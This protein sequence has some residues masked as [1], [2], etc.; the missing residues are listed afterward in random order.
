MIILFRTRG[1]MNLG[2]SYPL[3]SEKYIIKKLLKDFLISLVFLHE[4]Y[5]VE[6]VASNKIKFTFDLLNNK[7]ANVTQSTLPKLYCGKG[8]IVIEKNI[9]GKLQIKYELDNSLLFVVVAVIGMIGALFFISLALFNNAPN[10]IIFLFLSQSFFWGF[11]IVGFKIVPNIVFK[12]K[13]NKVI[14]SI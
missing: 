3:S 9:L 4:A 12:K 6:F 8:E 5:D 10:A 1:V 7:T 13:M 11:A 14:E 2:I